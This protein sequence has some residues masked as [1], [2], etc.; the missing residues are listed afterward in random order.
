MKELR[1]YESFKSVS[2]MDKAVEKA[3]TEYDLKNSERTV[4]FKLAQYSCKFVGVSYLKNDTLAQAVGFSKRTIQRALKGLSKLGV[5]TRIEQKRAKT[6]GYGAFITVIN[7]IECHLVLSPCQEDEKP[8]ENYSEEQTKK[9]ETIYSKTDLKESKERKEV[10]LD[11][12]FLTNSHIPEEFINTVKPFFDSAKEVYSLWGKV[13]LAHKKYSPDLLE[14]TE[15]AIQ[16]FKQSIFAK[17][18][19]RIKKD[20]K[21]YLFGVLAKML[22]VEQ[23]KLNK[24]TLWNWLEN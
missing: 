23:R 8:C 21:G 13:M 12:T 7:P 24:G 1:Q 19:K 14:Y 10:K 20:F 11:T 4:L 17:K 18:M 15:I 22:S 16:A 5:I 6:G 2:E 9:I 3:L